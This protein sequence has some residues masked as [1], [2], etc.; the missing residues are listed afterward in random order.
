MTRSLLILIALTTFLNGCGSSNL[1]DKNSNGTSS[2]VSSSNT[3]NSAIREGSTS[4]S[5][6][7]A[8]KVTASAQ[9]DQADSDCYD[10]KIEGKKLIKD[11]T[12]ALK[13]AEFPKGCFVT[14]GNRSD[15]LDDKD[16]PRGS[17]FYIYENGEKKFE[18][19]D[20][21]CGQSACWAEAV[22][23]VDLNGDSEKDV[24]IAG[25]CLGA[26]D[27]YPT[28]AVYVNHGKGFTTSETSNSQLDDMK[29]AKE[30]EQYVSSHR[31][32]FFAE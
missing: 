28:N 23:L 8:S 31:K 26:K 9:D 29:T 14:F 12:F 30:I 27:S 11:Q 17:T 20:A 2:P 1:A 7:S 15:M 3:A 4:S 24:I 10:A 18:F 13:T 32:E 25:R 6:N 5:V 16:L 22:R 21:F 19:P